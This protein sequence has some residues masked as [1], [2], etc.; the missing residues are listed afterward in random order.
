MSALESWIGKPLW[1]LAMESDS[2]LKAAQAKESH[3]FAMVSKI[4][5]ENAF[6]KTLAGILSAAE[7]RLR[8]T[9]EEAFQNLIADQP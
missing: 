9:G 1:Q 8:K 4:D 3:G 6:P 5:L 7:I 2:A